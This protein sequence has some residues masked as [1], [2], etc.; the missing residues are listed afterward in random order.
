MR[1]RPLK[2]RKTNFS[3]FIYR[4]SSTNP[5]NFVKIGLMEVE[6]IGLTEIT[7]NANKIK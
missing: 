2:N 7:K 6:I 3:S 5:A 1:Q 4:Q